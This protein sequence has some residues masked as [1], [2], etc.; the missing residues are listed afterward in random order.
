MGLF[1]TLFGRQKPVNMSAE[2]LF[3]LSTA[4]LTLRTSMELTPA[5]EAGIVFQGVASAPFKEMQ[6]ELNELMQF[7]SQ[8][9]PTRARAWEDDLGGKWFLL[10]GQDFQGLVTM[11]HMVSQNLVEHGFGDRLLAAVFRFNDER[12]RP[13]YWTYNYKRSSFYPFVPRPDSHSHHRDNAEE[14]HLST[15]MEQELPMEK[16]LERWYALWDLPF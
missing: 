5:G 8:N 6:R 14:L 9:N 2:R 10:E 12:S 4:E 7:A 13:V 1:D 11:A 15:A 16:E 3:A